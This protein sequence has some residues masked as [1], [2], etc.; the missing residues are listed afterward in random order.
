MC[1]FTPDIPKVQAPPPPAPTGNTARLANPLDTLS[2]IRQGSNLTIKRPR[3]VSPLR[4][5]KDPVGLNLPNT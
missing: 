1:D 2:Q 4:I 3:G 5:Q